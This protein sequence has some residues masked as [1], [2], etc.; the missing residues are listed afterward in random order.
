MQQHATTRSSKRHCW[1]TVHPF[2]SNNP[3]V[4]FF[5]HQPRPKHKGKEVPIIILAHAVGNKWTMMIHFYAALL[6]RSA[7][8]RA[9]ELNSIATFAALLK[10]H[11]R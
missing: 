4:L 11:S 1:A 5:T 2:K 8:V 7:V 3:S 9:G 6:A 10:T